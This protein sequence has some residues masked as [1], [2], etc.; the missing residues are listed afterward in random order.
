MASAPRV[1]RHGAQAGAAGESRRLSAR[2]SRRLRRAAPVAALGGAAVAYGLHHTG[3]LSGHRI[4]VA[5][6][7]VAA[8]TL[9][10]AI[11]TVLAR[12]AERELPVILTL[13]ADSVDIRAA[14]SGDLDFCA[15]L[16]AET[17]PHGFFAQLGHRF[18]RAYLATF[19]ASPHAAALVATAETS[20]VGM[21]VGILRPAAHSRW[22]L[23]ERGARLALLGGVA[24][25]ARPRLLLR[26]VRTRLT[27][28][29]RALSRR[30]AADTA[31]G[32]TRPAVLSHV[33]VAPG[34]VG[35]GL[36]RRLVDAFVDAAANAGCS[37]VLLV[38]LAGE[39]G[40]AGFYRSLGWVENGS[41][42]DFDGQPVT[43]FSL[44]L[45]SETR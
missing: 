40:A 10:A 21:V 29:R 34:A 38:T 31:G 8:A 23:R 39:D 12:R 26:F 41:H 13:R 14:D 3:P 43:A 9:V 22:V 20:P 30:R 44:P 7:I 1:L 4:S 45:S 24:L 19:V 17:L 28:Y 42:S 37:E 36:G 2:R 5:L 25:V 35:L 18:L 6:L 11:P 27:R 33:A 15:A 16:H 32:P